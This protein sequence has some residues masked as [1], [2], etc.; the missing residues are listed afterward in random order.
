[1][2]VLEQNLE[3]F[4]DTNNP[5]GYI[6]TNV[7]ISNNEIDALITEKIN[8]R[9]FITN[10]QETD[11]T[12]PA[13]AKRMTKPTYTAQEV[14]AMPI[15]GIS[16]S[17]TL[18]TGTRLATI[19]INGVN[20]DIYGSN[21][22]NGGIDTSNL[23][24]VATT[25]NYE[26]LI[27]KPTVLTADILNTAINNLKGSVSESNNT[28]EKLEAN[29]TSIVYINPEENPYN[30]SNF[31]TQNFV[32]SNNALITDI[33]EYLDNK[34]IVILNTL[35]G[36]WLISDYLINEDLNFMRINLF[37]IMVDDFYFNAVDEAS[38]AI[39]WNQNNETEEEY[40]QRYYAYIL[41]LMDYKMYIGTLLYDDNLG[42]MFGY[43]KQKD[44]NYILNNIFDRL[45]ILE[46]G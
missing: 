6:Q 12:V 15:D 5:G 17:N 26:D 30:Y 46:E 43:F 31:G 3:G 25:G 39:T 2:G 20:T 10:A 40:L 8:N 38:Q 34:Q 41:S 29:K 27:N 9:G 24:T 13:W 19:T 22:G 16:I 37:T 44:Y 1:M 23:A 11:P 4:L 36:S 28:L 35:N 33:I 18:N 42:Q 32:T 7:S 14:G 21:S 45:E